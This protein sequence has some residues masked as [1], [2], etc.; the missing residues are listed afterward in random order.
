ASAPAWSKDGHSL[1]FL[2]AR[3]D[4]PAR[5]VLL[6]ELDNPT[7][8]TTW[9]L[10]PTATTDGAL[11]FWAGSSKLVVGKTQMRPV[12]SASFSKETPGRANR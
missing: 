6:A 9:D 1:A 12:F 3:V 2:E 8:D 10:P 4:R 11:V 7:G 5:L